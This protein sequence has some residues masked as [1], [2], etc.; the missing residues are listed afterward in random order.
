MSGYPGGG[1]PADNPRADTLVS[2]RVVTRDS[3]REATPVASRQEVIPAVSPEEAIQAL[4]LP[5]PVLQL[6]DIP[7]DSHRVMVAPVPHLL[8]VPRPEAIPAAPRPVAT[9]PL[10]DLRWTPTCS[11]GSTPLT[12]T[13]RGRSRPR[14]CRRRSSTATGA[15]SAR[16]PAG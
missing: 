13:S 6:V 2:S 10:P 3:N 11:S 8:G 4:L 7:E 15:T 9:V 14:S 16:R 5:V 12:K 1:Y